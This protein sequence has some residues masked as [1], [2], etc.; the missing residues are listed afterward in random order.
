MCRNFGTSELVRFT[1]KFNMNQVEQ[2][3]QLYVILCKII[4]HFIH[5]IMHCKLI[6]FSRKHWP[7]SLRNFNEF[8]SCE[9]IFV[10]ILWQQTFLANCKSVLYKIWC[11]QHH[12]GGV[13]TILNRIKY[14]HST[15]FAIFTVKPNKFWESAH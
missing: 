14:K 2:K 7:Y 5:K 13:W 10:G 6:G 1:F 12:F 8:S 15:I 11:C 4:I 3:Q 9:W